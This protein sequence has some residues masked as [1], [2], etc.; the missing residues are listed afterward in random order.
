[1]TPKALVTILQRAWSDPDVGPALAGCLAVAGREGT[2]RTGC[3]LARTR[4]RRAK[5]GTL[6]NASAL[7]GYVRV[8]TRSRSSRT[9]R[10]SERRTRRRTGSRRC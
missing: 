5:T 9:A 2:L 10:A 8:R 3:E 1:M 6:T 7:S 4:E